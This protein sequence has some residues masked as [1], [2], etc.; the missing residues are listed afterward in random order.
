MKWFFLQIL[1]IGILRW[2][3]HQGSQ[4][5]ALVYSLVL[6]IFC[7]L[8]PGSKQAP[9]WRTVASLLFTSLLSF[10][11]LMLMVSGPMGSLAVCWP[12]VLSR[13]E[14]E[15]VYQRLFLVVL[16]LVLIMKHLDEPLLVGL[17]SGLAV[18][19]LVQLHPGRPLRWFALGAMGIALGPLAI[20]HCMSEPPEHLVK[21]T[22]LLVLPQLGLLCLARPR[23]NPR[24]DFPAL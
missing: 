16:Q 3:E 7:G 18:A 14:P 2:Q 13:L 8:W 10:T 4:E 22:L 6:I 12:A 20:A 23:S 9:E 5:V 11:A 24:P 17:T 1:A 19:S 21:N 15:R